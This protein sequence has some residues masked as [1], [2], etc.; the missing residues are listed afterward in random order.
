MSVNFDSPYYP[1][2]KVQ[3]GY[4][5]F[6]GAEKLPKK[7]VDYL[8]DMPDKNGYQ[9]A[10]DNDRA[11]VRL[12]KYL[13]YDGAN[14]LGRKLPAPGE[15]LSIVFDGETPILDTEEQ[16]KR[17]PLGYRL[18]PLE[19]WGQA[20]KM[21]QTVLKIYM[22]R[23]IPTSAFTASIGIYFD[24]LCNY[25]HETTTRTDDYSRSYNIE[26][27]LIEALD[28]VNLGGAGVISFD[29]MA[30]PDNGSR[31]IYDQ[32]MNVGRRLHMSLSW[33]EGDG[34]GVVSTY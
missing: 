14:P 7:L 19:Y 9:P 20:Q 11:R 10:D 31:A 2:D 33:A 12:M 8:L 18:Y 34:E 3:S 32:G 21:A 23:V 22:G 27:C 24:I 26:Q 5:T 1:F 13:C 29:R 25:G 17:H 4:S 16:K 30:H 28:G 6:A 15:K